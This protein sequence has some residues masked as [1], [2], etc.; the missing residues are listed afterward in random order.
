MAIASES[1]IHVMG[2]MNLNFLDFNNQALSANDHSARL[3]PLVDAL[4]DRV[5]PHGFSQLITDVT[6]IWPGQE[7]SLLD[8]HWT[9]RPEKLSSV[10]AFYQGGSDHKLIFVVRNTIYK[11]NNM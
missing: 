3:R 9:N 5:V 11:A 2:D 1:E 7:P 10:H 6:R 8:H 4:L